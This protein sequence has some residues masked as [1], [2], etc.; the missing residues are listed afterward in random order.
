MDFPEQILA[1]NLP[2]F[3][4]LV[5]SKTGKKPTAIEENGFKVARARWKKSKAP[6]ADRLRKERERKEFRIVETVHPSAES[7]ERRARLETDLLAWSEYYFPDILCDESGQIHKDACKELQYRLENGGRKA[8]CLPRGSGKSVIGETGCMWAA[9]TGKRKFIVPIGST[10]DNAQSYHDFV[11]TALTAN[12]RIAEDYPEVTTFFN[13]LEGSAHKAKYQIDEKEEP[14]G[15]KLKPKF[16][17]FPNCKDTEGKPY[18][19]AM[20]VIAI[21]SIDS[22]FRGTKY[23]R[24]DGR[25]VR[26][27]FILLDDI[28]DEETAASDVLSQKMEKKVVGAVLGLAGPRS[29]IACYFACTIQRP[30]DVSWLFL[31]RQRHPDFSGDN[32]PLFITWPKDHEERGLLWQQYEEI[33]RDTSVEEIDRHGALNQFLREH[34]DAMHDGAVTSWPARVREGELSAVQT[35]M[36]LWLENGDQFF[37]EYQGAP[38]KEGVNLYDISPDMVMNRATNRAAFEL[39]EWSEL[40]TVAT[41]INPSKYLSTVIKAWGRDSSNAVIYYG[42]Y[43]DSPLPTSNDM[44]ETQKDNIIYSALLKVGNALLSM[45]IRPKIWGMDAA[46]DNGRAVKRFCYEWNRTNPVIPAIA[47]YGAGSQKE[48]R[49]QRTKIVR[50]VGR[51]DSWLLK[52]DRD[53]QYGVIEWIL[54]KAD[55][56]R[57]IMLRSWTCETGAPGGSTLPKG[58]HGDFAYQICGKRLEWKGDQNGVTGYRYKVIHQDDHYADACNMC[59]VLADMNGIGSNGVKGAKERK[60]YT[61]ADLKARY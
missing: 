25:E 14:T 42:K 21:K 49:G 44:S 55:Y 47:M 9:L 4:E 51:D 46:G 24:I 1:L 16:I 57:D 8:K 60:K 5:K 33:W 13:A 7:M 3:R 41:D 38:V 20:C 40:V 35:G 6:N 15:I 59:H 54:F 39:P 31:D 34:W 11:V 18:P 48:L 19:G 17:V 43:E 10:V 27:D 37:S 12:E 32:I 30:G 28:Q 2:A 26:P 52:R 56:W 22:R 61:A 45:P 23:V 29:K 53:N 50:R 58:N 36:N